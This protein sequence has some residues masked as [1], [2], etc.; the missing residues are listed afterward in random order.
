MGRRER[1]ARVLAGLTYD[2]QSPIEF[3]FLYNGSICVWSPDPRPGMVMARLVDDAGTAREYRRYLSAR[4]WVYH[5]MA[6]VDQHALRFGWPDWPPGAGT[7][8]G[9]DAPPDPVG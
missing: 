3:S 8:A 5:T 7:T 2:G 9:P 1:E 4:G 6:E